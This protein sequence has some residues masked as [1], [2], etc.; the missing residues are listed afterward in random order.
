[1]LRRALAGLLRRF[2]RPARG[3]DR[4]VADLVAVDRMTTPARS[5]RARLEAELGRPLLRELEVV[6]ELEGRL[7]PLR[8]RSASRRAA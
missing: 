4:L 1:M 6:L 8:H 7:V 3:H 5:A 2:S